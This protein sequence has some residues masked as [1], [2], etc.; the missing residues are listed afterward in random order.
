MSSNVIQA[1]KETVIA[2]YLAA[3]TVKIHSFTAAN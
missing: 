2:S 1:H 3:M